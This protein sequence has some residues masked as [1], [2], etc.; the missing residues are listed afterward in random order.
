[1]LAARKTTID[2]V[3]SD[4]R[5]DISIQKLIENEISEKSVVKPEQ[6]ADFYAKNPDQFKQPERVRASHILIT[7]AK[8]ADA[9]AKT[10]ARAPRPPRF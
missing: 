7:V 10:Q 6:V 3:R 4:I 8:G 9:A 2:Q 5:D 1:M